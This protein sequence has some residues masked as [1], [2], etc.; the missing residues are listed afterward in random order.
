MG[1]PMPAKPAGFRPTAR[2]GPFP[3]RSAID[4]RRSHSNPLADQRKGKLPHQ[5][6]DPF[7]PRLFADGLPIAFRAGRSP[8]LT[9]ITD[10]ELAFAKENGTEALIDRLQPLGFFPVTDP[11]RRSIT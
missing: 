10:S 4:R 1:N 11:H 8:D 3:R 6:C 9:G 7:A 2:R 5:K